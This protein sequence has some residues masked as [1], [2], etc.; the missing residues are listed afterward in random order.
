MAEELEYG[1]WIRRRKLLGLGLCA[2]AVGGLAFVPLGSAYRIAMTVLFAIC[3]L[4]LLLPL[5][6]YAMFSQRGGRLQEKVY[7]LTVRNLGTDLRGSILDIGSGSGVL[8]VK[9]AQ[10]HPDLEVVGI[11]AWGKDWEYSKG[12]CERNAAV[13]GVDERVRFREGDAATLDFAAGTFDGVVS[14][15][16]FHEVKSVADKRALVHE[17]LRV[18]KPGGVFAFVD[19][20]Y[21]PKFYGNAEDFEDALRGLGLSRLDCRPLAIEIALPALLR[22]PRALGRVGIVSGEKRGPSGQAREG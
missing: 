4:S 3:L 13:A 17:A 22:H 5:Y 16:T 14:N 9:I 2:L 7:D 12:L 8:A 15:L 1:N 19:Y 6:A 18:T 11:D 20:F 10:R 21:E